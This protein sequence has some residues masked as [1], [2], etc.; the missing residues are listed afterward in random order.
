MKTKIK[1]L[2]TAYLL[3]CVM[4]FTFGYDALEQLELARGLVDWFF[5]CYFAYRFV[6]ELSNYTAATPREE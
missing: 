4:M 5:T 6:D 3:A 2:L 1:W